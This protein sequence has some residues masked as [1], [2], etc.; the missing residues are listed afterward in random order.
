MDSSGRKTPVK[1]DT[2]GPHTTPRKTVPPSEIRGLN[3]GPELLLLLGLI[4]VGPVKRGMIRP[5]R[6]H[7]RNWPRSVKDGRNWRR[8]LRSL[9]HFR[10]GMILGGG[11]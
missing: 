7:H 4:H 5:P 9:E 8:F 2:R 10:S 6:R 1:D 3:F 11:G